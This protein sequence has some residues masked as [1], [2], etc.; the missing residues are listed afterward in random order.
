M[1]PIRRHQPLLQSTFTLL[2]SALFLTAC[3]QQ[4]PAA[5]GPAI[6]PVGVVTLQAQDVTLSRELPGRVQAAQIAEI[7]PQV[8]GIVLARHFTEGSTV[9]AGATLYQIDPAPF[10]AA[11]LS[12]QAAAAKAQ[13]NIAST[14]AKA[15]R[16]RE[17]LKIKA[18][19]RQDFDEAEAAFLQAKADLQSAKA[20]ISTAQINLNYS[21]VLAP[22]AGQIGKSTVTTG[23]LVSSGQSQA[24]ATV[25]QLDPVFIDLTQ[26]SS[27]LLALKKRALQQA[28]A[29]GVIGTAAS[30]TEVS[31]TLDDGSVY[32]H[33]GTLQFTEVT[34]NPDTGS[35]TLR[36]SFPNPDQLLLPGMYVRATVH[37]GL[38]ANAMLVPQRG[39]SRNAKGEA[40]ALVVSK[41]GKVEPRVLQTNRTIGSNWLVTAGVQPGDQL[42]VEGLQKVRPG[43]VVQAVPATSTAVSSSEVPA[44]KGSAPAAPAAAR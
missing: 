42:I 20:Q 9:E 24:L 19:S 3:G 33:K 4:A 44:S 18:V 17:L 41:D 6:V 2:A 32:P 7:R 22:I 8:S 43:A 26:S 28:L 13:A 36:A 21:K 15:E 38:Q 29:K 12:A 23:A 31:L 37:E 27:E 1:Q 39:V 14:Q 11:L 5:A 10:S 40:T 30:Q 34:V 25:T 35:V 16:Y